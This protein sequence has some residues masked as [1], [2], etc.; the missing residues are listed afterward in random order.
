M[1]PIR[2]L[3][4]YMAVVF[5]GGPLLAPWLYH[6]VQWAASHGHALQALARIPFHRFVDRSLLGLALLGLYPLLRDVQMLSCR[7][8]G[9]APIHRSMARLAVG[10][11]LGFGSLACVAILALVCGARSIQIPH[12]GLAIIL[13]WRRLLSP[14]SKN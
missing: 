7:E 11:L 2:S 12:S 1:R 8:I 3:L 5:L 13:R 9:F 10:F 6:L 14:S 4:I